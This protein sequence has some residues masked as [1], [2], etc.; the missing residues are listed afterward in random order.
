MEGPT[1]DLSDLPAVLTTIQESVQRSGSDDVFL[2]VLQG[3]LLVPAER[4]LAE[5]V[6]GTI[7]HL[8]TEATTFSGSRRPTSAGRLDYS[9]LQQLMTS[10]PTKVQ[11]K[12]RLVTIRGEIKAAELAEEGARARART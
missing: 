10:F 3:L 7:A 12:E 11:F 6:W 2:Q 8:V 9:S 5:P 1:L 4:R